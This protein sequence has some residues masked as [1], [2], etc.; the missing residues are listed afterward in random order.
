[1]VRFL[2]LA[3]ISAATFAALLVPTPLAWAQG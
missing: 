3:A 2:R 1:M